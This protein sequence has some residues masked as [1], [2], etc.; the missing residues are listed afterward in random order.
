MSACGG[1]D[2]ASVEGSNTNNDRDSSQNSAQDQNI[3]NPIA[4]TASLEAVGFETLEDTSDW[5]LYVEG[6]SL[7]LARF[8]GSEPSLV[9]E[10]V[11]PSSVALSPN[12]EQLSYNAGERRRSVFLTDLETLEVV[13][14]LRASSQFGGMGP[15]SPDG[16]WM[17]IFNFP[18]IEVADTAATNSIRVGGVQN[19][20][21]AQF[22][23]ADSTLL[24]IETPNST[25]VTDVRHIDPAT[26]DEIEIDE[27]AEQN[28]ILA[29]NNQPDLA[30][31][32][33]FQETVSTTVGVDLANPTILDPN[34]PPNINI[35]APPANN[36]GV[37]DRCGTF[38]IQ[39]QPQDVDA[40]PTTIATVEDSVFITNQARLNDGTILFVR[41]HFENCDSVT[42]RAALMRL[43]PDGNLDVITDEIDPG[44][45]PNLSFFF[46]ETGNR[47]SISSDQNYAVWFGGGFA[48]DEA[49]LNVT[50]LDTLETTVLK[51]NERNSANASTFHLDSVFNFVSWIPR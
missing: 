37:P 10:F 40:Q 23:L 29:F 6:D 28:I 3:S 16:Q 39:E 50:R 43:N 1:K 51:R 42:M 21:F 38:Q 2:K 45:S 35:I 22:W 5:L 15:W 25:G 47:V 8:D 24:V 44:T 13:G 7:Y 4:D 33:A 49:T 46:G 27:A 30:S 19:V 36:Q 14:S 17:T 26:G 11:H 18:A 48:A 41:W 12:G 34:G 32:I 20:A 9:S 31:A